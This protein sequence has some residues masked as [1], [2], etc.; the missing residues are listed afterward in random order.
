[1]VRVDTTT[2]EEALGEAIEA[3]MAAIEGLRPGLIQGPQ[4]GRVEFEFVAQGSDLVRLNI[5]ILRFRQ[6][7]AGLKGAA[8]FRH[9]QG[10]Y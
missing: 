2:D 8:L 1:M 4:P 5:E 3:A 6:E 9:F 7:A 10:D